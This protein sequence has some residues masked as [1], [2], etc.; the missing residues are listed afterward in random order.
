M[1]GRGKGWLPGE[2][3]YVVNIALGYQ[4]NIGGW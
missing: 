3:K 4:G 1:G 2:G